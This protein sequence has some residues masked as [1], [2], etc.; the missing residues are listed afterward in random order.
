MACTVLL[1]SLFSKK[2]EGLEDNLNL[3]ACLPV[4]TGWQTK[5]PIHGGALTRFDSRGVV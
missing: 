4:L 2:L 1:L 3:A 5:E